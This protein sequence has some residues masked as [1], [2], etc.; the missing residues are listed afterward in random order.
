MV[1]LRPPRQ[2]PVNPAGAHDEGPPATV[3]CYR[4]DLARSQPEDMALL[5]EAERERARRFRF[6]RDRGRYIAAHAQARRLIGRHLGKDPGALRFGTTRHGKP[7]LIGGE[8]VLAFNLTHSGGVGYLAIA[9]FSVGIDVELYRPFADLQPLIDDYCSPGEIAALAALPATARAA[10][11]L[12]V[13]TRKEAAL[14]AWGTGIGAVPLDAVHVGIARP[15]G[16]AQDA[17]PGMSHEGTD[18]PALRLLTL[19]GQ[20]EVLSIAAACGEPFARRLAPPG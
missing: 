15:A 5:D 4:L 1:L 10:A 19:S 9:P 20:Q 12:G 6:D 8:T 7:V 17:L 11:F 14:K 16:A 2:P 3:D 18:H 13:W